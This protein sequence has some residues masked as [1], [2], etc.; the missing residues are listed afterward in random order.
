MIQAS[1]ADTAV[2]IVATSGRSGSVIPRSRATR[3]LDAVV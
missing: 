3:S 1:W 2:E